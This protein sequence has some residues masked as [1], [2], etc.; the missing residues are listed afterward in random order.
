MCIVTRYAIRSTLKVCGSKEIN[1]LHQNLTS[2][3]GAAVFHVAA[4]RFWKRYLQISYNDIIWFTAPL[5]WLREA[6]K[7]AER[8]LVGSGASIDAR[9][10]ERGH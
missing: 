8:N 4:T 6:A 7:T 1:S 9:R 2:W 10:F 3:A 5:G